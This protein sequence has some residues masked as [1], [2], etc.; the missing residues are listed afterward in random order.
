MN[1]F[2]GLDCS[3]YS[4]MTHSHTQGSHVVPCNTGLEE[5]HSGLVP[6][7]E[8]VRSISTTGLQWN[9]C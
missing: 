2:V 8:P 7:G 9:L 5:S 1:M 3:Q 6:V 4:L